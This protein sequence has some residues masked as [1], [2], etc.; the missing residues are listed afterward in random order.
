MKL[1]KHDS[2]RKHKTLN[3]QYGY[4]LREYEHK[5]HYVSFFDGWLSR[6][7]YTKLLENVSEEE[8]R[9]RNAKM[10]SFSMSLATKYELLDFDCDYSGGELFFRR[11]ES[12]DE[13]NAH[14]GIQPLHGAFDFSVLIP[15]LDAWYIAGEEDTHSFVLQ[16]LSKVELL[17]SVARKNGLYLFSND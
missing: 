12:I 15:E 4:I 2:I 11:F 8:Q 16:D 10:H 3:K 5:H 9:H 17:S 13:I 14:M 6:D 7:D 1:V